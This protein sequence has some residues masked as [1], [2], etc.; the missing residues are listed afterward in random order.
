VLLK[1]DELLG[2][3]GLCGY[4][5]QLLICSAKLQLDILF[6]HEFSNKVM[7]DL[8]VRPSTVED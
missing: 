4:I 5:W 2:L 6:V 3:D 8:K 7:A 1:I